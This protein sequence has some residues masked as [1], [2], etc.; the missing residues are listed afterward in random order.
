MFGVKERLGLSRV[1]NRAWVVRLIGWLNE[2]DSSQ[3]GSNRH[4]M[5]GFPDFCAARAQSSPPEEGEMEQ[6]TA[7]IDDPSVPN[8][9]VYQRGLFQ[10]KRPRTVRLEKDALFV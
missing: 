5:I 9:K 1:R 10:A 3:H 2:P 8:V 4:K 6:D 7:N